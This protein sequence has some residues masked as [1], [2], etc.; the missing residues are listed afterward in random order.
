MET[1]IYSGND[2]TFAMGIDK[3]NRAKVVSTNE[4]SPATYSLDLGQTYQLFCPTVTLTNTNEHNIIY[5]KNTSSTQNFIINKYFVSWN[6][7]STNYNRTCVIKQ[8]LGAGEPSANHTLSGAGNLNT[9]S[10][11]SA[12]MTV[13][14]WNGTG[15]G[16]TQTAGVQ[17]GE[18]IIGQGM[19][20]INIEGTTI[21]APGKTVTFSVTGDEIG[22][23]CVTVEG[24]F[25]DI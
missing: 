2:G 15:T 19:T 13:Y 6:G 14:Y 4:T 24:H 21:I 10:S 25:R 16:M 23:F 11:K 8:Y 20:L 12:S 1:L 22:K 17:A 9:G 18:G 5:Y 7:G 3:Y